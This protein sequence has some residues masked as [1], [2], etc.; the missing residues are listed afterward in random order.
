MAG[1]QQ[2]GLEDKLNDVLSMNA[3]ESRAA[4]WCLKRGE[5]R[6]SC[7]DKFSQAC[8]KENLFSGKNSI[9]HM[10]HKCDRG[11]SRRADESTINGDN[12]RRKL[13]RFLSHLAQQSNNL[14]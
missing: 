11:M 13:F 2:P 14:S 8:R 7:S 10:L 12:N 4:P 9:W 6:L 1:L 3:K 5:G